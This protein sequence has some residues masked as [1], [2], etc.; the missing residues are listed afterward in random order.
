M[1]DASI[2]EGGFCLQSLPPP[3]IIG[4][5]HMHLLPTIVNLIVLIVAPSNMLQQSAHAN[6]SLV[7]ISFKTKNLHNNIF[8]SLF[9]FKPSYRKTSAPTN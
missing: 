3:S 8:V 5:Y 9:Y 7:K 6:I 2:V 4:A 1:C